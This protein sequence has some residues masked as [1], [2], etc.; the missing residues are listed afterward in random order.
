MVNV[1]QYSLDNIFILKSKCEW[2][3]NLFGTLYLGFKKKNNYTKTQLR[4]HAKFSNDTMIIQFEIFLTFNF[5]KNLEFH[6]E[7]QMFKKPNF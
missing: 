4:G 2:K 5:I 6:L 1:L 3:N 7:V